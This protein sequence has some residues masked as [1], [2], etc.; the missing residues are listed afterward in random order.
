MMIE[1]LPERLTPFDQ[2]V[3][4]RLQSNPHFDFQYPSDYGSVVAELAG[5]RPK[6]QYFTV[7]GETR[8]V[9]WFVSFL[10]DDSVLPEPFEPACMYTQFD[11]R[12]ED[13]SLP[14][15]TDSECDTFFGC[16][17]LIPFAAIYS[18]DDQ[19]PI[20]LRHYWSDLPMDDSLCFDRTSNPWSVVYCNGE[21]QTS[22]FSRIEEEYEEQF[23]ESICEE[24]LP[25]YDLFVIPVARSFS[26]FCQMLR[27][28]KEA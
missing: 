26:D 7:N 14:A 19:D 3:L 23:S 27:E 28:V 2:R 20:T 10:D 5:R 16:T 1:C 9:A 11:A 24:I 22:E 21:A 18:T 25:R 12:V 13:R 8:R 15:I 4:D 17:R 6:K